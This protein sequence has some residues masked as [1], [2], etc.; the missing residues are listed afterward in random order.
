LVPI[1]PTW[2]AGTPSRVTISTTP[3]VS[4]PIIRDWLGPRAG[5][6]KRVRGI[7]VVSRTIGRWIVAVILAITGTVRRVARKSLRMAKRETTPPPV[8]LATCVY[9]RT[10]EKLPVAAIILLVL[11]ARRLS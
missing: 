11:A 3:R 10:T 1:K 7:P 5:P 9:P 6:T 4:V 2:R 8:R